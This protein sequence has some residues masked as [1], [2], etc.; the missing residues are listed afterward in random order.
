[1]DHTVPD[2]FLC[3]PQVVTEVEDKF[4]NGW[5]PRGL[6]LIKKVKGG[7]N[8]LFESLIIIRNE[9]LRIER[10]NKS[11]RSKKNSG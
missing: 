9:D 1:M 6:T 8:S 4:V 3:L 10:E 11:R 5:L 7:G 2:A